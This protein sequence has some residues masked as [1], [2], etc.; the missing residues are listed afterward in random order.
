[1]GAT[2]QT[3]D[4]NKFD[5]GVILAQTPRPGIR[6]A[7]NTTLARINRRMA[8]ECADLLINGLKSGVHVPPYTDAGWM[9]KEMEAEGRALQH[10]PKMSK[11]DFQ[12]D[13]V[14]WTATDW[15]RRLQVSQS[16]WTHIGVPQQESNKKGAQKQQRRRVIFHDAVEVSEAEVTGRRATMEGVQLRPDGKEEDGRYRKVVSLD[17]QTESLYILLEG[18]TWIR[19]RRATLEGKLERAAPVSVHKLVV[20]DDL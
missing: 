17:E 16:V 4:E 14:S 7:E 18:D 6:I 1:M 3:L 9:A 13:W 20:F 2:L 19:C 8:M 15:R 5:H 11:A 10:A 12:I